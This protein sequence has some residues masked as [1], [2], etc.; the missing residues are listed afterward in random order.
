MRWVR[1]SFLLLFAAFVQGSSLPDLIALKIGAKPDFLLIFLVFFSLHC[2]GY[3]VV[4]TSFAI[5]L[6]A[7]IASRSFGPYMISFGLVGALLSGLRQ[8]FSVRR[9]LHVIGV[10]A[11]TGIVAGLLAQLLGLFRGQNWQSGTFSLLFGSAVYSGVLAPY[12]FSA[13]LNMIDWLGVKKYH[14]TR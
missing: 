7:D 12:V 1:F 5:G 6:A 4:I 3:E 9:T 10:V 13:F 14:L 2:Y 8:F 11:A